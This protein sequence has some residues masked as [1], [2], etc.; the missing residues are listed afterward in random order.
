MNRALEYLDNYFEKITALLWR[1]VRAMYPDLKTNC[2]VDGS[3]I[4]RYG[5]KGK[6]VAVEEGVGTLQA[7][8]QFIVA[9]IIGMPI[10]MMTELHPDNLNDPPQ[11]EDFL[12]RLMFSWI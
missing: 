11:Y 8:D 7:Q 6:N 12:S 4:K 5:L 3:F 10:P 9:Q 1:A 2:C